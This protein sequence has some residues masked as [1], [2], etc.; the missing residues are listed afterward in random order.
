MEKCKRV[1]IMTLKFNSKFKP[2]QAYELNMAVECVSKFAEKCFNERQRQSYSRFTNGA[3]QMI[4]DFCDKRSFFR[5]AYLQ[6]SSC[7]STVQD[8]YRRCAERHLSTLSLNHSSSTTESNDLGEENF[9]QRTK[10]I[11]CMFRDHI[12]CTRAMIEARCGAEAADLAD[13]IIT[14]A[15]ARLVHPYCTELPIGD[16]GCSMA[17]PICRT[18]KTQWTLLS[19]LILTLIY[20]Y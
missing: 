20:W 16:G 1:F 18:S 11:C 19:G 6:H 12:R 7:F 13:D 8:D 15:T 5:K 9:N 3:M 10:K 17:T 2:P 14:K 4:S